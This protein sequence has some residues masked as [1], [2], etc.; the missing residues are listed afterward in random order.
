YGL[1]PPLKRLQP[2]SFLFQCLGDEFVNFCNDH[3]GDFRFG[4][5]LSASS[6]LYDWC[7]RSLGCQRYSFKHSPG[8]ISCKIFTNSRD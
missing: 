2:S 5:D 7:F 3:W 8:I 4:D 6:F 1:I